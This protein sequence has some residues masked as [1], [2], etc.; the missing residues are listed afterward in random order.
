MLGT[1]QTEQRKVPDSAHSPCACFAIPCAWCSQFVYTQTHTGHEGEPQDLP[2]GTWR[3]YL[4]VSTRVVLELDLSSCL[5]IP[6]ST[7]VW[8][9][10]VRDAPGDFP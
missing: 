1:A 8:I 5:F 7:S 2:S 9:D 10:V 4:D 3:S 6:R